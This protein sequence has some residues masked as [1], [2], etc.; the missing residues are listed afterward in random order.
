[1]IGSDTGSTNPDKRKGQHGVGDSNMEMIM[2]DQNPVSITVDDRP[3]RYFA[4]QGL[5]DQSLLPQVL[6]NHA[7]GTRACH[8]STTYSG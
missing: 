5:L 7:L 4:H 2:E 1:M 3:S 8:P 6:Q